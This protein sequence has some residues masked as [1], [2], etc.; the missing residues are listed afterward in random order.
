MGCCESGDIARW[1]TLPYPY[2]P[3]EFQGFL[4]LSAQGWGTRTAGHYLVVDH[5]N[6]VLGAVGTTVDWGTETAEIGYWLC[7]KARGNGIA[8]IAAGVI[9]DWLIEVGFAKLEAKVLVG[10]QGSGAVLSRL[11]LEPEGV[12]RSAYVGGAEVRPER[13]DVQLWGRV[14]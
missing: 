12:R 2:G 11:G 4:E 10:N 5:E 8:T 6:T 7:E 13:A 9:C 14:V 1:T 3:D